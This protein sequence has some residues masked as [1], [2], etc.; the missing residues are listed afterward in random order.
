MI[1]SDWIMSILCVGKGW[2]SIND[3]HLYKTENGVTIEVTVVFSGDDL[4]VAISGGDLPHIGSVSIAIPRESL[5]GDGS[6]SSTVSTI[7]LTGHK[8]NE[9]GD[10]FAHELARHTGRVC[11]VS[12]GVHIDFL[13]KAEI[14]MVI[15]LSKTMLKNLLEELV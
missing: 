15:S 6:R 9:I 3:L 5:N 10:M 1:H 7:N 4:T 12:C 8:D 14:D 2:M 13:Y 11:V